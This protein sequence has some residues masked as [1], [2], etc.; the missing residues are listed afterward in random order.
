MEKNASKPYSGITAISEMT[1]PNMEVGQPASQ[2]H[3]YLDLVL[4]HKEAMV[5]GAEEILLPLNDA[6]VLPFRFT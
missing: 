1:R 4:P 5:V 2:L 6:I 3:A